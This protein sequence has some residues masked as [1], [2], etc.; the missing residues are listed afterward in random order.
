MQYFYA[1]HGPKNKNNFAY[2]GGYGIGVKTRHERVNVGDRVFII[3]RLAGSTSNFYLCG[4]YEIA[5]HSVNHA[6]DYPYR[7]TLKDISCLDAF[8]MLDPLKL[9]EI[10]PEKNGEKRFNLFQRHFCAQGASFAAPL[11]APVVEVL[12]AISGGQPAE[13]EQRSRREDGLRMVK[14]RMDQAAFRRDVLDNWQGKCAVTGSSLAIEA[15]HIIS[16]ADQGSSDVKN[17]IALAADLHH[18]FDHGHLSFKNNKVI[19]S[20]Q[21]RKEA[22]YKD[23]HNKTLQQSRVGVNFVN[24]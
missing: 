16:H 3:Q 17:G 2:E 21:A 15:C 14:I 24:G 4:E 10:L 11:G 7:F 23:L 20:E 22:R 5:G 12:R 18:L 9:S 6:S 1:Y 19:L 8:I 13:Y